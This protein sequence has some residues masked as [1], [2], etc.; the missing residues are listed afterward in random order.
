MNRGGGL[1]AAR[2]GPQGVEGLAPPLLAQQ[3]HRR[4][5]LGCARLALHQLEQPLQPSGVLGGV[6]LQ[7]TGGDQQAG[8]RVGRLALQAAQGV[9]DGADFGQT[10][11]ELL[12]SARWRLG[13]AARRLQAAGGAGP[14]GSPAGQVQAGGQSVGFGGGGQRRRVGGKPLPQQS[15]QVGLLAPQRIEGIGA[16]WVAGEAGQQLLPQRLA[17]SLITQGRRCQGLLL[18]HHRRQWI[19]APSL[20]AQQLQLLGG[21]AGHGAGPQ[22]GRLAA[23]LRVEGPALLEGQLPALGLGG[24]PGKL[25]QQGLGA[26]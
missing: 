9:G 8:G 15:V 7:L 18:E 17:A 11:A 24:G 19:A 5:G 21:I 25:E 20:M 22:Q 3:A 10:L 12:A 26:R 23:A 6:A 14:A 16:G 4:L 2:Q 13:V 1:P